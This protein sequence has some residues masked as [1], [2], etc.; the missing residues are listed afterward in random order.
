LKMGVEIPN[1]VLYNTFRDDGEYKINKEKWKAE[2]L[3]KILLSALLQKALAAANQEADPQNQLASQLGELIK[4][5]GG[6][7]G[8]P[9]NNAQPPRLEQKMRDGVPDSTV[10]TY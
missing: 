6:N 10:A 8:R 5:Q 4:G 7:E 3:E 1:E 9:P 2:Q